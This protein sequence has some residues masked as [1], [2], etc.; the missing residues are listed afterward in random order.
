MNHNL[1][2]VYSDISSFLTREIREKGLWGDFVAKADDKQITF[3]NFEEVVKNIIIDI[4]IDE[5]VA[6]KEKLFI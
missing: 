2:E 3:S 6:L 1:E 4:S 5:I